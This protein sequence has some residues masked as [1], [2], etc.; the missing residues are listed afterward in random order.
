MAVEC[1]AGAAFVREGS[2]S[3]K[4][5]DRVFAELIASRTGEFRV[6]Y[7]AKGQEITFCA[8]PDF[9]MGALAPAVFGQHPSHLNWHVHRARLV[10]V[11]QFAATIEIIATRARWTFP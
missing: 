1:P 4:A 9:G 3:V 8:W 7:R 2:K 10:D 11:H 5:N 6:L